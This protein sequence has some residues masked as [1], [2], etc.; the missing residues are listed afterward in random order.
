MGKSPPGNTQPQ[1][2]A[3]SFLCPDC[4]GVLLQSLLL[5]LLLQGMKKE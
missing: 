2:V 4:C 1:S 3:A 5:L